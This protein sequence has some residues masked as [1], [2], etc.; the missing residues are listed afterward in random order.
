MEEDEIE[1][2]N[3]F[4][5]RSFEEVEDGFIDERGFY[6]TPNGSFWDDEH[7]YF[8][9]CGFDSHGGS[10]DIY[11][12]YIPGP[13]YD[14]KAGLYKDQKEYINFPNKF[15]EKKSNELSIFKLKEQEKKDER[16]IKKYENLEEESENSD[17]YG[18]SSFTFDEDDI[19]EAYK[20]ALQQ[21]HELIELLNPEEYTGIIER[22]FHLFVYK[23]KKQPEYIHIG[24][25]EKPICT[26][27]MHNKDID[28]NIG[29][30][31]SHIFFI[32]NDILHLNTE[33]DKL[34]YSKEEL[35]KAFKQAENNYP[36]II[37]KTYGIARRKNFDFPSPK[38]YQYDINQFKEKDETNINEWK[39]K[40]R[41]YARGI[42]ADEF[43]FPGLTYSFIEDTYNKYFYCEQE[44]KPTPNAYKRPIF[45]GRQLELDK[46]YNK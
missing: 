17:D 33:K 9:S 23:P 37:R 31:C 8:N 25:N 24:A 14:E 40:E 21:E 10:Y 36:N 44:A 4:F 22:D 39:V 16:I 7:N 20:D 2:D 46:L 38:I 41:L 34:I 15:D 42:I 45:R 6:T 5:Q 19:K 27:T 32:L 3:T 1:N 18:D 26:C 13:N 28:L 43:M 11:G 29:E 35:K 12:V 30:R